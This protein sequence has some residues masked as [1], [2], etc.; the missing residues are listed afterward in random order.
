MTHKKHKCSHCK[1]SFTNRAAL[2]S[3]VKTHKR[4]KIDEILNRVDEESIQQEAMNVEQ[5]DPVESKNQ[6]L[7]DIEE[8]REEFI[9]D[10]EEKEREEFI[11]DVEKEEREEFTYDV[12]EEE[13]DNVEEVSFSL[14]KLCCCTNNLF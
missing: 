4:I 13:E 14:N 12:E 11:Y 9:Y 1:K 6:E 3:H 7:L 8:E 5:N 10:V 2:K